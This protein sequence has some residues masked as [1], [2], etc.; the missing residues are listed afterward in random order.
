MIIHS[1][2]SRFARGNSSVGIGIPCH[3]PRQK[4][5][6]DIKNDDIELRLQV[7]RDRASESVKPRT[8]I[9]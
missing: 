6:H 4:L 5:E 7:R 9:D 2:T 3:V 8:A 1:P